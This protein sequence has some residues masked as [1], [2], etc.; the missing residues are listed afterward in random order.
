VSAKQ[1]AQDGTVCEL[2][3]GREF[4]PTMSQWYALLG[5]CSIVYKSAHPMD[6]DQRSRA[7]I[8]SG[9]EHA[10]RVLEGDLFDIKQMTRE[11]T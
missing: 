2:P 8:T 11:L 7:K 10:Y 5:Q 3:D 6:S 4:V 1:L 9:L